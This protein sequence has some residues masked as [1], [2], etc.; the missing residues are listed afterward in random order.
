MAVR[1]DNAAVAVLC[2]P[3]GTL[4]KVIYDEL[5]LQHRLTPGREFSG[6]VAPFHRRRAF[7]FLRTLQAGGPAVDWELGIASPH[8][9]VQL[10]FSG[11]VTKRGIVIIGTKEPLAAAAIPRERAGQAEKDSESVTPAVQELRT[12]EEEKVKAERKLGQQLLRL[13]EALAVSPEEAKQQRVEGTYASKHLRLLEIA[14]HDLRNPVSGVLAATEY[15]IEDAG[16]VLEPHHLALLSSIESSARL[17]LRL[18]EDMLEI[19]TLKSAK[20]RLEMRSTDIGLLLEKAVAAIRPLAEE[21]RVTIEISPLKPQPALRADS[22]RLTDALIGLLTGAIRSSSLGARVELLV[23]SRSDHVVVTLRY[24]STPDSADV[25]KSLFHS[26]PPDR[27]SKGLSYERAALALAQA[28]RIVEAHHGTVH[29][30]AG[31]KRESVITLKLPV[32]AGARLRERQ[33]PERKRA[34]GHVRQFDQPG[35]GR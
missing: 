33:E 1:S 16:R 21:K 23:S 29:L 30:E 24:E 9:V 13:N 11:A 5:G 27:P 35:E 6:L 18:L 4:V 31:Q 34:A 12:W 2:G 15:L 28:R 32:S 10:Y 8:G 17:M 20:V 26:S 3:S 22:G 25:L 7:R 19:P 14:A